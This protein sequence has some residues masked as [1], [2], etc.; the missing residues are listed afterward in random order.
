MQQPIQDCSLSTATAGRSKNLPHLLCNCTSKPSSHVHAQRTSTSPVVSSAVFAAWADRN[1]AG[2]GRWLGPSLGALTARSPQT[3]NTSYT[4][5]QDTQ[6][7]INT[8]TS[9]YSTTHKDM[10]PLLIRHC[11]ST[12]RHRNKLTVR[13]W[14]TE[15]MSFRTDRHTKG[16]WATGRTEI[17]RYRYKKGES[18]AGSDTQTYTKGERG[19]HSDMYI[20]IHTQGETAGGRVADRK[21]QRETVAERTYRHT[22]RETAAERTT[23]IHTQRETVA[24]TTYIHK[25]RQKE[26]ER[27][28]QTKGDS[29]RNSD[30][31][32]QKQ[33]AAERTTYRHTQWQTA[34]NWQTH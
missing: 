20:Y 25:G 21:M 30:R 23:D 18:G 11:D 7:H 26:R 4:S 14:E 13:Q 17:H 8:S 9:L 28:T 12:D 29:I 33:S 24:E 27:Q 6:V 34:A 2:N 10:P 5:M 1:V 32:T 31:H 19:R 22:Q 3:V 16:D 15:G